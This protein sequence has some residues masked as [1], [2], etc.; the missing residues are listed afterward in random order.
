MI[1]A[2]TWRA[3]HP[4]ARERFVEQERPPLARRLYYEAKDGWRA[5]LFRIETRAGAVGEP[6]IIVHGLLED[7][8]LYRYGSAPLTE[9]LADLGFSVYLLSYRSD[10]HAD[11]PRSDARSAISAE[12][13]ADCDLPAALDAVAADSGFSKV[14]LLGHGFGGILSLA[15]A[16]RRHPRLAGVIALG[17]PLRMS[18]VRS[19]AKLASRV[20]GWLPG[21]LTVPVRA[22]AKFGAPLIDEK[23]IPWLAAQSIPE[24][25]RGA[26]LFGT[27]DPSVALLRSIRRWIST[28]APTLY[29]GALDLCDGLAAAEVPLLVVTGEDDPICPPDA[30]ELALSSW[31]HPD[32][33]A[34]RAPGSHFDLLLGEQAPERVFAPLGQWLCERRHISP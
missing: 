29:N 22:I 7:P 34:V 11:P 5:P 12:A 10:R 33:K 18:G 26:L 25:M 13:I 30:G 6:I 24:R 15:L 21:R 23:L 1:A 2:V 9:A 16:G 17:A 8:D 32:R 14:F 4:S 20:L 28:G 31:G 27:D 3:L 19:E